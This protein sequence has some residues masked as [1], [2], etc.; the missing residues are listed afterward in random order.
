MNLPN[1]DQAQVDRKKISVDGLL[2]TPD[3]RNP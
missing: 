2:E 1:A 3:S